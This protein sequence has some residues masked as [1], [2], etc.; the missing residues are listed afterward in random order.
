MAPLEPP[1]RI[2]AQ[3]ETS[4]INSALSATEADPKQAS[5]I[6]EKTSILNLPPPSLAHMPMTAFFRPDDPQRIAVLLEKKRQLA[7]LSRRDSVM[8]IVLGAAYPKT[9]A[10]AFVGNIARDFA[11][12]LEQ[13]NSCVAITEFRMLTPELQKSVLVELLKQLGVDAATGISA[14]QK[15]LRDFCEA[16]VPILRQASPELAEQVMAILT[17]QSPL[18]SVLGSLDRLQGTLSQFRQTMQDLLGVTDIRGM[19]KQIAILAKD[20][21]KPELQEQFTQLCQLF[22]DSQT[23]LTQ[24][25]T[26]F[27]DGSI[28]VEEFEE[29]VN[30]LIVTLDNT[31][32]NFLVQLDTLN[33]TDKLPG[34]SPAMGIQE[35]RQSLVQGQDMVNKKVADVVT[36]VYQRSEGKTVIKLDPEAYGLVNTSLQRLKDQGVAVTLLPMMFCNRQPVELVS[37]ENLDFLKGS[38]EISNKQTLN[39]FSISIRYLYEQVLQNDKAQRAENRQQLLKDLREVDKFLAELKEKIKVFY[40]RLADVQQKNKL[41][42]VYTAVAMYGQVIAALQ[43]EQAGTKPFAQKSLF[44]VAWFEEALNTERWKKTVQTLMDVTAV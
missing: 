30:T 36:G 40:K 23:A 14:K 26:A 1:S 18:Q 27:R 8:L 32:Q 33:D 41:E 39:N 7:A 20:L 5:P 9:Q 34:A 29:S 38:Y 11:L 4:V 2:G 19:S 31:V 44:T 25:D 17:K 35:I 15:D 6:E 37:A 12:T 16:I 22:D 3:D 43:A 10:D 42:K 21:N 24:L 28:S 13:G